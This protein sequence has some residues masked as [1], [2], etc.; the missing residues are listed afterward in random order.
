MKNDEK[1]VLGILAIVFGAIALLG[2][3]IPILN[4]VSFVIAIPAVILGIIGLVVNRKNNKT[5]AIIGTVLSVVAMA[6][7]LMTQSMY[8]KALDEASK[9]VDESVSKVEKEIE[10]SQQE[11]DDKFTWTKADFDALVV[12]DSLEGT[13]GANYNDVIAKYGEPQSETESTSGD[14]TSK[15]VDYDTFGG[16]EYKSVSLEFVKQAD[17]SWLLS[18]KYSSGLK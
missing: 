4:N 17:E 14:Y 15:Y 16:S 18:Y 2:S 1:K 11:V 12:G 5:L 6:V 13:G 3:W 8:G 10:S 9:A 7:V